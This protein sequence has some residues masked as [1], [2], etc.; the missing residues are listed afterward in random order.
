MK[1]RKGS[2]NA[3]EDDPGDD[4]EVNI[5]VDDEAYESVVDGD[6]A[7]QDEEDDIEEEISLADDSQNDYD[8]VEGD[9]SVVEGDND[10]GGGYIQ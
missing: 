1:R 7:T 2:D 4:S 10:D 8:E 3:S 9:E 5:S 6:D